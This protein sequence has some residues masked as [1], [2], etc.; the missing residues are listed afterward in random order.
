MIGYHMAIPYVDSDVHGAVFRTMASANIRDFLPD[1][2]NRKSIV[3]A[4]FNEYI[5]IRSS[6]DIPKALAKKVT[7]DVT[8]GD[9][10]TGSVTLSRNL[11]VMRSK[12]ERM[13]FEKQHGRKA[14]NAENH[15][16]I[17]LEG[18]RLDNY[19]SKLFTKAG[20]SDFE[21]KEGV[22]TRKEHAIKRSNISKPLETMEI[23]FTAKIVDLE[24]FENAWLNGIGRY[25]TYG[26]G[27]LRVSKND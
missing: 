25:K 24:A 23:S 15:D 2:P 20:L 8:C 21:Y 12:E 11:Q 3:F 26:F 6:G 22:S 10:I 13:A 19:L 5:I 4:P 18:E 27:M 1:N 17:R 9:S 14:K 16:Y 7:L